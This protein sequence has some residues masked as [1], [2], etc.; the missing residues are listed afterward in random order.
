VPHW[1]WGQEA[2]CRREREVE[3]HREPA[4]AHFR[5]ASQTTAEATHPT[6]EQ[7]TLGHGLRR[8]P[9]CTEFPLVLDPMQE[10]EWIA[11]AG[12]QAPT[13][14]RGRTETGALMEEE[15]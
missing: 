10:D 13:K 2:K 6:T 1:R 12:T 8:V 9:A 3:W 7:T 14:G 15:R 4:T 5:R 11:L